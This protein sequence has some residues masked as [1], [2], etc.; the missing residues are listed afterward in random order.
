MSQPVLLHPQSSPASTRSSSTKSSKPALAKTLKHAFTRRKRSGSLRNGT[1]DDFDISSQR[2]G[3]IGP[4]S[5]M[6]G[7]SIPEEVQMSEEVVL[8]SHEAR[9][10]HP[11]RQ[12]SIISKC[13]C[14]LVTLILI[15]CK[16]LAR[17]VSLPSPCNPAFT[18]TASSKISVS[19]SRTSQSYHHNIPSP[20]TNRKVPCRRPALRVSESPETCFVAADIARCSLDVGNSGNSDKSPLRSYHPRQNDEKCS[21]P[22]TLLVTL[23]SSGILPAG[24]RR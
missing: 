6:S 11:M 22:P 23:R 10:S 7:T 18:I 13:T 4:E 8:N 2:S 20:S 24:E 21:F 16:P 17:P 12:S 5:F 3:S 1:G 19:A 14:P 9:Y 15:V